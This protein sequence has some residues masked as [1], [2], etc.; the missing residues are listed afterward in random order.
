MSMQDHGGA[1]TAIV[2]YRHLVSA[3]SLNAHNPLRVVS[4]CDIDAAYAAFEAKRLGVDPFVTP[5]AVQ[6]W[7]VRK[8]VAIDSIRKRL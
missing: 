6:Q 8:L 4:L 2:T 5:I 3:G 1:A 7:Q